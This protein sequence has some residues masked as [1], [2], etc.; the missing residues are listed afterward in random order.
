MSSGLWPL[1]MWR[2]E[3]FPS[4]HNVTN[5][6]LRTLELVDQIHAREEL[7]ARCSVVVARL[8]PRVVEA[9]LRT[10]H[11]GAANVPGRVQRVLGVLRGNA[12]ALAF[13]IVQQV[14]AQANHQLRVDL[15]VDVVHNGI[16][17]RHAGRL[18]DGTERTIRANLRRDGFATLPATFG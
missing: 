3:L 15:A 5:F 9:N 7:V 1:K 2:T 8:I 11:D 16:L 12:G 18:A 14:G 10:Q 6:D 17:R 13:L 4:S